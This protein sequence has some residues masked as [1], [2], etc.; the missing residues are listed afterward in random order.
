MRAAGA[1]PAP[2]RVGAT[3]QTVFIIT[4][5]EAFASSLARHCKYVQRL[6]AVRI[7]FTRPGETARY[8]EWTL[9]TFEHIASG[10]EAAAEQQGG[11]GGLCKAIAFIDLSDERLSRI[12]ELNPLSLRRGSWPAVVAMLV[13]AFPE[14]RWVLNTPLVPPDSFLFKE[15]HVL[16]AA[17]PLR[18]I[19]KLHKQGLSVLFD[20]TGLRSIIRGEMRLTEEEGQRVAPY[21]PV[22]SEV[23]ASLDEEEDYAYLNA[24]AAYRFG[25][26][27]HVLTSYAM[28]KR[29]LRAEDEPPPA[30]APA[31]GGGPAPEQDAQ[32]DD[33]ISLVFEDLYLNFPDKDPE[34]SR[35]YSKL[36]VR[37]GYFNRLR[38]VS[39]RIFVTVGH[40]RRSE[41]QE[42]WVVNREHLQRLRGEGKH[43]RVVYKPEA[44][45]F[46]LW[47]RSG[48]R[49]RLKKYGG[50]SSEFDWPPRR[51]AVA[52]SPGGHSAPGRLLLIANKLIQRSNRILKTAHTLPEALHGAVLALE[53]QE[54]LGH[55]TP[56]TSLE[57]LAL[58]HQLEVLAECMFYGVEYNMDVAGRFDE[59]EQ[60]VR[61]IGEWFKVST[62]DLS[63]RNAE[64]RIV[65]ELLKTFRDHNQFDEEQKSLA[66]I[67]HLHRQLWFGRRGLW[68]R[69]FYPIRW[70]IEFLLR[71]FLNFVLAIV[72]WL[73]LLGFLYN[74]YRHGDITPGPIW[75][76]GFVDA[77][78]SFIGLSPPHDLKEIGETGAVGVCVVAI[79]LGF[80]HLGIFISHLYSIIARK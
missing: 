55:R 11:L 76:H 27:C 71:S 21:I 18:D 70:Y 61:S 19:F 62:R 3:V 14:V 1:S 46:D 54:Y 25:F 2:A 65:S 9:Q 23:A 43:C 15:V 51:A 30:A 45:I 66:R 64:L 77:T 13:L 38:K 26:R 44:G 40:E 47:K 31:A 56:T 59:I 35:H 48:L 39:Q 33:Q 79:G 32:G 68:A 57:A 69:P 37:D 4:S 75:W 73:V 7:A 24:Y 6:D 63:R 58:K 12:D 80:V 49:W 28:T 53:A 10:I 36:D 34:D 17:N 52:E 67:R 42:T 72:F 41:D 60:E 78:V 50:R 16:D 22:R 29:V 8:H 74:Y 5:S 20:P